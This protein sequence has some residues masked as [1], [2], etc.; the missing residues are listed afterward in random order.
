MKKLFSTVAVAI[1][2]MLAGLESYAQEIEGVDVTASYIINPHFDDGTLT[3]GAPTGWILEAAPTQS[4][5][6]TSEKAGGV[7]PGSQNHWQLWHASGALTGR[8]YQVLSELPAGRY[9][10]GADVVT[11][12]FSGAIGL[13]AGSDTV[14]VASEAGERYKVV[15]IV[16]NGELEI[17]FSLATTSGVTLD[18]DAFTLHYLGSLEAGGYQ[19]LMSLKLEEVETWL[20]EHYSYLPISAAGELDDMIMTAEDYAQGEYTDD[21]V[22]A[23]MASLDSVYNSVK[24]VL[25]LIAQLEEM[26]KETEAL[27]ELGY[28]GIADLLTAYETASVYVEEGADFEVPEG[29]STE[30]FLDDVI[31][32]LRIAIETY[33]NSQVASPDNPADYT[34]K[35]VLPTFITSKSYTIPDPWVVANVQA[36]GDIWV[37]LGHPDV[38]AM[39]ANQPCFNSWSN[40]FTTMNVY[41]DIEE[42]PDGVYTV[43]ARAITQGLGQQHSYATSSLGTV[44]SPDMTIVGWDTNEWETLTTDKIVVLDGKLRIG[45]A[46]TSAGDI[47]GWFQVTD[48]R[49]MYYGTATDEDMAMVWSAS[50]TRANEMTDILLP[51]DSKIIKDAIATATTLAEAGKYS[52]ACQTLNAALTATDSI[53]TATRKFREGSWN[54]LNELLE[55]ISNDAA[56]YPYSHRLLTAVYNNINNTLTSEDANHT[57]LDSISS[58]LSGYAIY[59]AYLIEAENI[60]STIKGINKEYITFVKE[61]VIAPQI[62]DLITEFRSNEDCASLLVK[63]QKAIKALESTAYTNLPEGD[64]TEDLITNPTIDDAIPTGWTILKGNGNGPTTAG[65]HYDGTTSNRYLDSW[66]PSKLNYTAYQEIIGLPDGIYR[67]TVAARTSGENSWLFAAPQPLSTDTV[68]WAETTQWI[69]IRNYG[70]EYG[71]IWETDSLAWLAANGEGEFPYFS[72]NNGRGRGWSYHTI[73]VEVSQH[74]LAIGFTA[75]STL[76][77]KPAFTGGW[78]SAD[79]WKLE[80]V[81]KAEVQSEYNPFTGVEEVKNNATHRIIARNGV[82]SSSTGE[83]VSVYTING[84]RVA[85]YGLS[86]GIYIVLCQGKATKILMK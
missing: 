60:L 33:N 14:F 56:T 15:T 81:S 21:E 54:T 77:R 35:I 7:I 63:L 86:R 44:V 28:A 1:M 74:Y 19:E 37:G 52:D 51:G 75:D 4:K 38:D 6:S 69:M 46:S 71:E 39:G 36:S 27:F 5:I 55:S 9:A 76:T 12:G 16:T 67:L 80:L 47:N 41:Q 18:F 45:F 43:S 13:Y 78:M 82:V 40:N 64:L 24:N 58:R 49:L 70:N 22:L 2:A 8:A 26:L 66:A 34:H 42:L 85:S 62:S 11:T 59:S 29:M 84:K 3:D 17:G 31:A 30:Q 32:A 83:P 79:D 25:V 65:E 68:Q 48:F 50:L 57:I 53:Y 73:D 72:A 20:N 23:A 61:Q 10:L